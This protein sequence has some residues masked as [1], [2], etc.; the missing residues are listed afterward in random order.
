MFFGI[1]VAIQSLLRRHGDVHA[2]REEW[3][4]FHLNNRHAL[5]TVRHPHHVQSTLVTRNCQSKHRLNGA[6]MQKDPGLAGTNESHDCSAAL[7][8]SFLC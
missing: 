5:H 4:L 3:P 6:S 7:T 1:T 2:C 8:T